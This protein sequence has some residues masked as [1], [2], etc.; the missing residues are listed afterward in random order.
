MYETQ[1]NDDNSY[2]MIC[3]KTRF[4][5]VLSDFSGTTILS[6]FHYVSFSLEGKGSNAN[7]ATIYKSSACEFM[8]ITNKNNIYPV[9]FLIH[10]DDFS[11]FAT[12][13]Q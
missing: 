12:T 4:I 2:G 11:S 5:T 13:S 6:R 9:M 7:V 1:L 3:H 10:K 8:L